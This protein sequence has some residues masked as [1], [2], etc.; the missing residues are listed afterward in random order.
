[1]K[2]PDKRERINQIIIEFNTKRP[3]KEINF[4]FKPIHPLF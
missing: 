2:T 4:R 3:E 1:M